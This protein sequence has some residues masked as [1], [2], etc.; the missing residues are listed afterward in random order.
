MN[1]KTESQ[2]I[3]EFLEITVSDNPSEIQERISSLMVFH[4]R[5][6]FMLAEAKKTLSAKKKTEIINTVIEIAK[7][8]HL[9]AKAQNALVDSIALEE[10]YMVDWLDRL[11][12]TCK[13]QLDACR[14]LLSYEKEV[15]RQNNI[16]GNT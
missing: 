2:Q 15:Y 8:G 9:S 1:T 13:H 7:T 16:G 4:A 5:T 6:G 11:N 10:Q 3:Q 14:S 12:S